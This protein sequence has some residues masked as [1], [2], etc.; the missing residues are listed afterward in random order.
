MINTIRRY[1][2]WLKM[3]IVLEIIQN[4][5]K[6]IIILEVTIGKCVLVNNRS[7]FNLWMKELLR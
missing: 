2:V 6:C 3:E 1:M 4:L 5:K 7:E